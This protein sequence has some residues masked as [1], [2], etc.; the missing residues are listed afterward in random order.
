MQLLGASMALAG[1]FGDVLGI[2]EVFFASAVIVVGGG[3]LSGALFRSAPVP[4]VSPS[5]PAS[6]DRTVVTPDVPRPGARP[7]LEEALG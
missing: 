3:V 2:R 6:D 7:G 1:A 4:A 5:G